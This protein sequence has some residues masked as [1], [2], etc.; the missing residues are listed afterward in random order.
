MVRILTELVLVQAI[1]ILRLITLTMSG[2]SRMVKIKGK[3]N[4]VGRV[5]KKQMNR[6]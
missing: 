3:N 1:L 5:A 2:E 4:A 6:K